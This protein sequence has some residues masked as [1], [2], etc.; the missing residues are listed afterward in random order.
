[1]TTALRTSPLNQVELKA[2]VDEILN[3][4]PAVGFALGV[5]RDGRL[6]FFH[7]HGLADLA[8]NT[9][10]TEDTVFRIGSL[11]KTFT[12]VAVM[13][14]WER[15]LV[16]LDAPANDYLRAYRLV[17]ADAGFRP[18]T[19]RHLLTHT[20]GIPEVVY[21]ADLLHPGW[22]PFG[23]RP[24][25][26]SVE[27]G[28]PPP[29]LAAYYRGRLRV[30][31]EPGTAFAYTNHGFAT[32]GQIVADVTG[33][34]LDRYFRERIFEPL[35]MTDTDFLRSER[36][37]GRLATGYSLGPGGAKSITDREWVSAGASNIYSTTRD[38]ARYVAA[39]LG[40]GANEHGS[41]IE[42]ATLAAMFEPHYRPD[43]RLWGV[44]LGFFRHDAGGHRFAEHGGIM[45][46]F[47]SEL[48]VAPDD[49]VG[50][51]A[52]TN[53]S[54]GAMAWLPIEL[55]RL[56]HHLLVIP[57]E[58]VRADIPHHPEIWD[59]ICG[60]YRLPARIADLRG[61]L[62]MAGGVEVFVR[63]GQLMLRV[64]TPVPALYRGFPLHPDDE[65]DPY[66]FRLDLSRFGM[67]AVR[68]VFGHEAGTG[69]KVVHTD[70]GSQPLSFYKQPAARIPPLWLT[71]AVGALAV[72]TAVTAVRWR[73]SRRHTGVRT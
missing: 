49:G 33:E 13:Q 4:H 43:P 51:I 70:L 6:A 46:G 71:G 56:L 24:A 21:A 3:R 67:P 26:G 53:G 27:V 37:T 73:R 2:S 62:M 68:L 44:G 61:R 16:D 65:T 31:V 47:H 50:I 41:V 66:V 64:L 57:D 23:D 17:P 12:A 20:A 7:G 32:L 34:P 63:R 10:V 36:V 39:L 48:F 45:P 19:V 30:V 40:G 55:G 5:V 42:P 15:G 52:F 58:G 11:T 69:T 60:R 14:L 28:E 72:A 54:S 35:G 59:E 22:G 18:A 25:V 29:S 1:M 9:P 8:S 38:M